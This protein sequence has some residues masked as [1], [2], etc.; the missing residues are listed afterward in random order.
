MEPV[1][2]NAHPEHFFRAIEHGL[3]LVASGAEGILL[4]MSRQMAARGFVDAADGYCH[5]LIRCMTAR[6]VG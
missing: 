3:A 5:V 6:R 1:T 4:P 2:R